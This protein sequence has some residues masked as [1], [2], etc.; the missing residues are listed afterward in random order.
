[1]L[2]VWAYQQEIRLAFVRPAKP[3]ENGFIIGPTT[4]RVTWP[5]MRT[6]GGVSKGT[7]RRRTSWLPSAREQG[8]SEKRRFQPTYFVALTLVPF[9]DSFDL[10]FG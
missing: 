5:L 7:R 9:V 1:M 6:S 4:R 2:D 8:R 10:E 3:I